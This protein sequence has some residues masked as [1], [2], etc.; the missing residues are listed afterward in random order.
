MHAAQIRDIVGRMTFMPGWE[1]DCL[2]G[3]MVDGFALE[4]ME[5]P[6]L[7][8]VTIKDVEDSYG[9]KDMFG[10][11]ATSD[12]VSQSPVPEYVLS[13]DA[14]SEEGRRMVIMFVQNAVMSAL[15]HE[16]DEWLKIDGKIIRN[17]HTPGKPHFLGDDLA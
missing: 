14:N 15:E 13:F 12:F 2:I 5:C 1:V 10:K 3:G 9:A 4:Y 6:A 16:A 7:I 8:R 11:P 17:P